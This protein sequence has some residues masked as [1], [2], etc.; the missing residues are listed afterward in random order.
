MI[1]GGYSEQNEDE[2]KK[3]YFSKEMRV[4]ILVNHVIDG[5]TSLHELEG[6]DVSYHSYTSFEK[7]DNEYTT[8]CRLGIIFVTWCIVKLYCH[9]TLYITCHI[10]IVSNDIIHMGIKVIS[11]SWLVGDVTKIPDFSDHL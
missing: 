7:L 9:V 1:E 5:E 8:D 10:L 4:Y 6:L 11:W 2:Q 3:K